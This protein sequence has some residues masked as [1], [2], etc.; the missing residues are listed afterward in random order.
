MY[1]L[2]TVPVLQKP[3]CAQPASRDLPTQ[4]Q[5]SSTDSVSH[6]LEGAGRILEVEGGQSLHPL[7]LLLPASLAL[8]LSL[9]AHC[10]HETDGGGAG[11]G[12]GRGEVAGAGAPAWQLGG[13][14]GPGNGRSHAE[15]GC[16][17]VHQ[18][19]SAL[20][21]WGGEYWISLWSGL[22]L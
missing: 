11:K 6:P 9:C 5:A 10:F 12:K 22:N 21:E 17:H 14:W 15:P 18:H 20:V 19:V 1:P 2:P 4:S 3:W 13:L 16:S 8:F 7:L